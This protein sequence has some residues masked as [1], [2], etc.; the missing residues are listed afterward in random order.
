MTRTRRDATLCLVPDLA[1]VAGLWR[2]RPGR[3]GEPR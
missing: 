3:L 1:L 2:R